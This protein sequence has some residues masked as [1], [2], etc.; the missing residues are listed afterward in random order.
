METDA[1]VVTKCTII[2]VVTDI[3]V[4]L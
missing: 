3:D 2:F 4:A 1:V